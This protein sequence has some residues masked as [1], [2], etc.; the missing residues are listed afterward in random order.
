[1]GS[2]QKSSTVGWFVTPQEYTQWR[3]EAKPKEAFLYAHGN[4]HALRAAF[5]AAD[6]VA[7]QA[8]LDA[9]GWPFNP[10]R[11]ENSHIAQMFRRDNTVRVSL[12]QKRLGP[13]YYEYW[14]QKIR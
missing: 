11:H 14:A 10:H 2:F 8:W 6:Q 7:E 4:L 1:M 5:P 9:G 13:H 12:V 3:D